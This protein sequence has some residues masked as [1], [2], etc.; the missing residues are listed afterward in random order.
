MSVEIPPSYQGH[1]WMHTDQQPGGD[2]LLT[3]IP[4][5]DIKTFA[6]AVAEEASEHDQRTFNERVENCMSL[7]SHL[8]VSAMISPGGLHMLQTMLA[9]IVSQTTPTRQQALNEFAEW[10]QCDCDRCL[11]R[12]KEA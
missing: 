3:L 8:L 12:R 2:S 10:V 9:Q 11:R 7:F 6:E 1:V 5:T 4:A